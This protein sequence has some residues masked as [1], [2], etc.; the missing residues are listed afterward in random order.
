MI[1]R[2]QFF[3]DKKQNERLKARALSTG[4]SESELIR[5]SVATLLEQDEAAAEDWKAALRGVRGM[6]A[7]YDGIEEIIREG[8]KS[9]RRRRERIFGNRGT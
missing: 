2:K 8:R 1:V 7:D 6:W 4:K 3:I 5:E 9:W